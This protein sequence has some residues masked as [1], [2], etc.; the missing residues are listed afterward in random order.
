[1][2]L[3]GANF[4]PATVALWNGAARP[5]QY[6]SSTQLLINLTVADLAQEGTYLISVANPAPNAGTS[7]AQPFALQLWPLVAKISGA[8]VALASDGSGNYILALTG[9]DFTSYQPAVQWNGVALTTTYI[10]PW[11]ISAILPASLYAQRP[12]TVTVYNT[13]HT[14]ISAGFVLY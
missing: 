3:S 12:A 8:S 7:V 1:V 11:E 10:S 6:F 2:V 14:T 5:T 4:T 9:T 13:D